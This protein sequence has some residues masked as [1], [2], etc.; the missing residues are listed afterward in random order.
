MYHTLGEFQSPV[1]NSDVG[2]L[3]ADFIQTSSQ[4]VMDGSWFCCKVFQ[5]SEALL[6]HIHRP[7]LPQQ[8]LSTCVHQETEY[9][10][11]LLQLW[12]LSLETLRTPIHHAVLRMEWQWLLSLMVSSLFVCGSRAVKRNLL[13]DGG[14]SKIDFFI[15]GDLNLP[16]W[17][18]QVLG[19][20]MEIFSA[21]AVEVDPL[22]LE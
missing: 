11:G 7:F 21:P 4:V 1:Q 20:R 15:C 8:E 19:R 22:C 18:V 13:H 6:L 3:S 5:A 16:L 12:G 14:P 17:D 10:P 9:F 2:K